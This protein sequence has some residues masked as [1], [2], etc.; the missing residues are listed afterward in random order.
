MQ[1][2]NACHVDIYF[3]YFIIRLRQLQNEADI[4]FFF[5]L[6]PKSMPE[7][8]FIPAS[9]ENLAQRRRGTRAFFSSLARS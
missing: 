1:I 9:P 8:I 4:I 6:N 7:S 2:A 3:R 5:F